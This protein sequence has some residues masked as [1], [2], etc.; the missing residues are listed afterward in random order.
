MACVVADVQRLVVCR[1]A[2]H[3]ERAARAVEL[4][5][6]WAD[7]WLFWMV[8]VED[9]ECD[10]VD[11]EQVRR[12]LACGL[13]AVVQ[14]SLFFWPEFISF[15]P[16]LSYFDG[17]VGAYSDA[18]LST[19]ESCEARIRRCGALHAGRWG[20][21]GRGRTGVATLSAPV[22]PASGCCRVAA[23]RASKCRP[24]GMRS[25]YSLAGSSLYPAS[26]SVAARFGRRGRRRCQG[27]ACR[28][29]GSRV[30]LRG[31]QDPALS[32]PRG[33]EGAGGGGAGGGE[34]GSGGGGGDG[35]G[36]L[37]GGGL[38]LG[39]GGDGDGG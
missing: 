27:R 37:G 30:Q 26:H 3:G 18:F 22:G 17:K 7:L 31:H 5:G 36:G 35:D 29:R 11:F 8:Q 12:Q 15:S 38:G 25:M 32:R 4:H 16:F 9:A 20:H 24:E 23:S 13:P 2:E 14:L 39:G 21:S 33:G 28:H 19:I 10:M 1:V 6:L 34:K